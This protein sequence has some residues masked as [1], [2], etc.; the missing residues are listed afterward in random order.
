MANCLVDGC[1]TEVTRIGHNLCH[2]HWTAKRDGTLSECKEC[3]K[4]LDSGKPLCNKCFFKN[5]DAKSSAAKANAKSLTATEVG[6]NVGLSA[7]KLNAIF[8]ELGWITKGPGDHG[9][10][11]TPQGRKNGG[12]DREFGPDKTPFV[13]WNETILTNRAFT[14]SVRE[15]KG[16]K[17]VVQE[18]D[19]LLKPEEVGFREK[20]PATHRATDGHMVRSRGELL[21]DNWLYTEQIIH[22][23]ERKVPIDEDL[24][25]D[26]YL[27]TGKVYIEYWGLEDDPAYVSRKQKKIALYKSN[28]LNLIE[29]RNADISNIDDVLPAKLRQFGIKIS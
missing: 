16:E 19:L 3:R 23:Y 7:N 4:L 28:G 14:D 12:N 1:K 22:A 13:A 18:S 8:V 29:I 20:F 6:K 24:Y 15:F 2:E 21:I 10:I 26:F 11:T 17:P 27:P 5:K 9:W 25:C